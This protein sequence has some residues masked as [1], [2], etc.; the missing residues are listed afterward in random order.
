MKKLMLLLFIFCLLIPLSPKAKMEF[1]NRDDVFS[2]LKEAFQAQVALSE[3]ERSKDDINKILEPYFTDKYQEV[4]LK[5][6]V[7][8][9]NGKYITY[10]S[11]F[12]KYYIPFYQFSDN[13]RVVIK[14]NKVYVFEYFPERTEG[15]VGYKSHYEG[16]LIE[17]ISGEWKIS[18]YLYNQIPDE[19]IKESIK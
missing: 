19:I 16:I 9:K 2:F 18:K 1:N 15:P 11:D 10:G 3:K 6:N 7:A 4:F 8:E 17:N 12:A 13:T 14:S 5:E